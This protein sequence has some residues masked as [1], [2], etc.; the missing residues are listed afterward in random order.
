MVSQGERAPPQCRTPRTSGCY[1][2]EQAAGEE[3]ARAIRGRYCRARD[4]RGGALSKAERVLCNELNETPACPTARPSTPVSVHR[5]CR[6][7]RVS[8][9]LPAM[10]PFDVSDVCSRRN[11][12]SSGLRAWVARSVAE[13]FPLQLVIS[14][15][16][17]PPVY[18][19]ASSPR[20][21]ELTRKSR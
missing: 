13:N 20:V 5:R 21:G 7:S 17:Y 6:R 10:I 8:A 2:D 1:G 18:L 11:Y 19:S 15:H 4:R 3:S 9:P 14:L 16:I 12:P